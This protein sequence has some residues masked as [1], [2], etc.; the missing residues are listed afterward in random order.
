MLLRQ[1]TLNPRPRRGVVLLSVLV[2]LV[3]LSLAAYQ[4]SELMMAARKAADSHTRST[5]ARHLAESGVWYTAAYLASPDALNGNPYD[6]PAIFQGVLLQDNENPKLRG[7]FS[8][9]A[10]L[11]PDD[12]PDGGFVVGTTAGY[13]FGVNDE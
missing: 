1:R 3:L 2:V 8:V 7:R 12:A 5:Q 9:V 6:N 10:L 13:R 4:Y 11:G